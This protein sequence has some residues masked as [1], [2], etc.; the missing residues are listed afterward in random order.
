M[1]GQLKRVS[2][3][4][5]AIGAVVVTLK[6]KFFFQQ[7]RKFS[8]ESWKAPFSL[9]LLCPEVM[10]IVGSKSSAV[11]PTSSQLNVLPCAANLAA[12]LHF[13]ASYFLSSAL[14]LHRSII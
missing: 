9:E 7:D 4:H 10:L 2:W 5:S 12:D 1:I 3:D 14:S 8:S 11:R 6:N 13:G